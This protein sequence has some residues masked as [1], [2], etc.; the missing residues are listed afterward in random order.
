[1]GAGGGGGGVGKSSQPYCFH[2]SGYGWG[3]EGVKSSHPHCFHSSGYGCGGG[4]GVKALNLIAS[5]VLGKDWGGGKILSSLLPQ[6][7]V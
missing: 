5:T 2:S 3:R 6:F 1:M 4:R 7:W